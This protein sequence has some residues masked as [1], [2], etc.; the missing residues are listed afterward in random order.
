MLLKFDI[1]E[2]HKYR[3]QVTTSVYCEELELIII[4]VRLKLTIQITLLEDFVCLFPY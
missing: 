1:F 2:K 4:V 3:E